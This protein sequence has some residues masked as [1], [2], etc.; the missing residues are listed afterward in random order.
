M[1]FIYPDGTQMTWAAGLTHRCMHLLSGFRCRRLTC[2]SPGELP[3]A[4]DGP[5]TLPMPIIQKAHTCK[6][7]ASEWVPPTVGFQHLPLPHSGRPGRWVFQRNRNSARRGLH[8]RARL[9]PE[10]Q[11]TCSLK[12][13]HIL[14][15][16]SE[17]PSGKSNTLV[18]GRWGATRVGRVLLGC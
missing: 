15:R 7:A 2:Y 6:S 17:A 9:C 10:I 13:P 8:P 3:P 1:Y 12:W 18:R 14:S 16:A 11:G 4:Q 5:G